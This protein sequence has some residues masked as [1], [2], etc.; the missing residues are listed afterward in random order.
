MI[1]VVADVG[2]FTGRVVFAADFE[3]AA[4]APDAVIGCLGTDRAMLDVVADLVEA[5][6]RVKLFE[7]RPRQVLPAHRTPLPRRAEVLSWAGTLV[8]LA[9]SAARVM[10][11]DPADRPLARLR[12]EV[13]GRSAAALR[14]RQ[15]P[16]RWTRRQLTPSR[17]DRR[18][19]LRHDRYLRCVASAGCDLVTWP[20][21]AVTAGGVRTCDGIEHRLDIV[22][23]AG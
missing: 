9:R 13:D 7:E 10:R 6:R 23:V 18:P 15:V 3:V 4:V 20:V 14:R 17:F 5:G 16:D 19:A 11:L 12:D 22:V 8:G 1:G 21:A 2:A